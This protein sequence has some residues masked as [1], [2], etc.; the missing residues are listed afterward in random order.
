MTVCV[1]MLQRALE[2]KKAGSQGGD[3]ESELTATA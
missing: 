1:V 3:V 2:L